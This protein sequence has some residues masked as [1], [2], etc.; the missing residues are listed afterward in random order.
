VRELPRWWFW[1]QVILV[2]AVV[3]G[4]VIAIVQLASV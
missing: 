4:I 3:A 1:M 2:I